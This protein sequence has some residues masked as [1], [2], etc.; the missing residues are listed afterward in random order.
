MDYLYKAALEAAEKAY[1]PYSGFKVGAAVE[2]DDGTI[3]TG[4]NQENAAYSMC[5]CAERVAL[6]YAGANFPERKVVRIA[7]A[8]PSSDRLIT[9]CGACRQT[10][11]E[12]VRRQGTEIEVVMTSPSEIRHASVAELLPCAFGAQD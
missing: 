3:V 4:N 10:M 5:L 8:T 12:T 2:L 9:P 7:V 11:A 1:A 6:C